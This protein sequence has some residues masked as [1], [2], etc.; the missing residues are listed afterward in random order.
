MTQ[1]HFHFIP[2]DENIDQLKK[3]FSPLVLLPPLPIHSTYYTKMVKASKVSEL[4][5][6]LNQ[7]SKK[8]SKKKLRSS[9]RASK[10]H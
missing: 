3:S 5:D 9:S 2:I 7:P 10:T 1:A 6:F 8:R 4:D